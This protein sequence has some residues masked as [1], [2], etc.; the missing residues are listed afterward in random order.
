ME[1]ERQARS[2]QGH[3][4]DVLDKPTAEPQSAITTDPEPP[5]PA[6]SLAKSDEDERIRKARIV[7]GTRLA[8]PADLRDAIDKASINIAG[9]LVPPKPQ[10]PDNCC[11][12][13]CVNCIWDLYRDEVEEWAAKCA[14]ARERI[15]AQ[16]A[17]SESASA[18]SQDAAAVPTHVATSMDDDGG[19]SETNWDQG[20]SGDLFGNVPVGIREF[21]RTEKM[22]KE[23]KVSR[24]SA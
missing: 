21:M 13:G 11:M 3:Y 9:I 23:A 15:A 19:A 22:L 20:S 2:L 6:E 14:Q 4:A 17:G 8:G 16:R 24:S 7:F 18:M 10:E 12:S 1:K 5:P